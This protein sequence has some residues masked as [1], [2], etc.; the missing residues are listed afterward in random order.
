MG[1]FPA[2]PEELLEDEGD[3]GHEVDGVV[4]DEHFPG[5]VEVSDLGE[6]WLFDLDGCGAGHAQAVGV[7]AGSGEVS[8]TTGSPAGSMWL[9]VW[10]P[11]SGGAGGRAGPGAA[12]PR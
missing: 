7:S 8:A 5:K 4:P 6:V 12:R 3:V 2:V 9:R 1:L 10:P 11:V